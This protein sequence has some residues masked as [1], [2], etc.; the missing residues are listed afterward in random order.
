MKH[1]HLF[2]KLVAVIVALATILPVFA[3]TPKQ[4]V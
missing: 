1:T 3:C 2:R 4:Q